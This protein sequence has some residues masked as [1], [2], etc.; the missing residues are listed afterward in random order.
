MLDAIREERFYVLTHPEATRARVRS[1]ADDLLLD[2][3]PTRSSSIR[4]D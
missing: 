1:R 2:R 4:S 3:A